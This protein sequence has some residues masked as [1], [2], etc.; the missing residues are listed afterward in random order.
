MDVK[1]KWQI[2]FMSLESHVDGQPL[3]LSKLFYISD[4]AGVIFRNK[5]YSDSVILIIMLIHYIGMLFIVMTHT[6]PGD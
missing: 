5:F 4:T 1:I 2:L 6:T 3:L